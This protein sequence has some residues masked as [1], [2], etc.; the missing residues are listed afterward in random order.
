MKPAG[1]STELRRTAAR[2]AGEVVGRILHTPA[3]P[4][5]R[6]WMWILSRSTRSGRGSAATGSIVVSPVLAFGLLPLRR[7]FEMRRPSGSPAASLC[8]AARVGFNW[9][10]S[11][12]M[13]SRPIPPNGGRADRQRHTLRMLVRYRRQPRGNFGI[14]PRGCRFPGRQYRPRSVQCRSRRSC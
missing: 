10:R 2:P 7:G 14:R 3:A 5:A 13:P 8:E 9:A 12:G 1:R 11:G 4:E 6:P